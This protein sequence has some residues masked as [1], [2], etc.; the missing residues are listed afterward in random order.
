[1]R[2]FATCKNTQLA[3]EI[4]LAIVQSM[5]GFSLE[6][7][8]EPKPYWKIQTMFEFTFTVSPANQDTFR[9][10]IASCENGWMHMGSENDASSV[11]NRIEN[12]IF[13]APAVEWAEVLLHE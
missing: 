1:M 13:L 8:S 2:V 9:S 6:V 12:S 3:H 5:R 10:I 11:W 7:F 4:S